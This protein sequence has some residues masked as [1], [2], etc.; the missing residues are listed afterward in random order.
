[1]Q[2]AHYLKFLLYKGSPLPKLLIKVSADFSNSELEGILKAAQANHVE[3][4]IVGESSLHAR[5]SHKLIQAS[6][7]KG[8]F[9]IAGKFIKKDI[10]ES[11][12]FLKS[13]IQNSKSKITLISCGGV[14]NK[15]DVI[16]MQNA[17]AELVLVSEPL[18]LE[19]VNSI[20]DF[21]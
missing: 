9:R 2:H 14:F 6:T 7:R 19:T 15:A 10:I 16:D 4:I 3:G 17:G 18:L 13:K 11:L 20:Y 21:F 5:N 1:M 8:K 12:K